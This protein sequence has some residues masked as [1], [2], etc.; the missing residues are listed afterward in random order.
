MTRTIA[1]MPDTTKRTL[2]IVLLTLSSVALSLIFACATPFAAFGTLAALNMRRSDAVILTLVV[3]LA[4]QAVGYGLLH[5]PQTWDSFA[6]GAAIGIAALLATG[7]AI[8]VQRRVSSAAFV[9]LVLAFVS[10]FTVYELTLYAASF[11][12]PGSEAAFAWPVVADIL[13]VNALTLLGLTL[14]SF[15]AAMVGF[16]PERVRQ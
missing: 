2:W 4:N 6:W 11:V 3:W 9:G 13:K 8:A 14:L 15:G 16:L 5:F 10:A 1:S 7:A 12:L